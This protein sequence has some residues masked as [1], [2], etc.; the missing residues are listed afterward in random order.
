MDSPRIIGTSEYLR[1]CA[2]RL[3][4]QKDDAAI[5]Y[6]IASL[7]PVGNC[8]LCGAPEGKC[9]ADCE[10]DAV[11]DDK[12]RWRWCLKC[13]RELSTTLDAYYGTDPVQA[14]CCSSCRA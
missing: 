9:A 8:R 13:E 11:P 4:Y 14:R 1:R 6:R 2:A 10:D 3:G 7:L 12:V 5:D